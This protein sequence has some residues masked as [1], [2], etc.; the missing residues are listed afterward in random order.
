MSTKRIMSKMGNRRQRRGFDY[1]EEVVKKH[2]GRQTP[3]SGS[4]AIKGDI[5]KLFGQYRCECKTTSKK[6]YSISLA[7]WQELEDSATSHGESPMMNVVF[8]SEDGR[9]VANLVVLPFYQFE[10]IA[11]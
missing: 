10:D 2:G 6:S 3:G 9:E 8:Y 4:K 5:Q 1:E 11:G 7:K